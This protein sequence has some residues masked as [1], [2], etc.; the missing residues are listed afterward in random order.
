MPRKRSE[1]KA[2]EGNTSSSLRTYLQKNQDIFLSSL[3]GLK[4]KLPL[5][6]ALDFLFYF[7]SFLGL[8][9]AFKI[10]KSRYEQIQFPQTLQGLSEDQAQSLLMQSKVFYHDLIIG[11]ALAVLGI[12]ILFSIIKGIIW[13]LT[14][15][16]RI[17]P[18]YMGKFLALNSIWLTWWI[19]LLGLLSYISNLAQARYFLFLLIFLFI[20]LS[21]GMYSLFVPAQ[22]F[23]SIKK[24]LALPFRKFHLLIAPYTL[25]LTFYLLITK[26][27]S[28]NPGTSTSIFL[29]IFTL[30]FI[31]ISRSYLSRLVVELAEGK[32]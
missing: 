8:A 7:L 19:L 9:Q 28:F 23:A 31:A 21:M 1:G 12:I 30:T 24:G 15:G 27:Y 4:W 25:L 20:L 2:Q 26:L 18:K 5:V 22:T 13:A 17:T 16:Q 29:L 3:F 6:I 32:I 11:I 14:L 10:L